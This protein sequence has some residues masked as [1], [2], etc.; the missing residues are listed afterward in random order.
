MNSP[1]AVLTPSQLRAATAAVMMT[2]LLGALDQTIVSVAVPT[3]ARQL[4]GFE[5]M[6]WVI[7]GY[8]IASTAVTPLYG[9][10]SDLFG[11]RKVMSFAIVLFLLAS[12]AC[13]LAQ[14]LPQLV[15]ARVLQGAGGGGLITMAQAVIADVVP[16]RERGRYQS[17][18]SIV[19]AV[20][21]ML[22]PVV[23]GVLTE[24]LSW[25]W[26]FWINLPVGLV[27]LV[28]VHRSLGA[29]PLKRGTPKIDGAGAL[30]L[31]SGLTAFLI[32]ITRVGQGTPWN[33]AANAIGWAI[34]LVLLALFVA[35][36]RRHP[37]AIVPMALFGNRVV[38]ACCALLF[39]CFFNFIAL[40]VLVPLRLQLVAGYSAA[41]AGLYLLPMTLAI[42]AAAF[43]SGRWLYRTGQ[44]LPAQRLGVALVPLGLAALGFTGPTSLLAAVALVVVGIGMGLQMPTTLIT[45]QQSVPREQV[46]TVTALTAFFRLLGGAIGIAVL[47]SVALLLLR[48]HLPPGVTSLGGEGL[49]AMLDAARAAHGTSTQSD[50][51]FRQVMFVSAVVSLLSLWLVTRLPDIR[52][53]D[54]AISE[55]EKPA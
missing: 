12:V 2:I 25:P 52:L 46:G 19:W 53:H 42:P 43:L 1:A 55:A 31:L 14:T 54:V 26:I 35:Q 49:G 50:G 23:G 7:S 4:G 24:Y 13:A 48:A 28:L 47:S 5:W 3:I 9:K 39:V 17:Y 41:D 36:Q 33:D 45:V 29:L 6:A 22:G 38:V 16:L 8:L 18:I 34:A 40:S 51:A 21:S 20:A 30:L 10:F 32:P 27:A 44:V 37:D 15:I 11:R